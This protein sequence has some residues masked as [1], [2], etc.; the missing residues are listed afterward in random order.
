MIEFDDVSIR[1]TYNDS[2]IITGLTLTITEGEFVL[3]LGPT[4]TG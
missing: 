1:Y 4:G 3:V 2:P